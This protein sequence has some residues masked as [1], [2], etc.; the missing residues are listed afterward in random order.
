MPRTRCVRWI[1]ILIVLTMVVG[2]GDKKK[3]KHH[4]PEASATPYIAQHSVLRGTPRPPM[5]LA[6]I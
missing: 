5:C 1:Y 3:K 4:K 2:C 6:T